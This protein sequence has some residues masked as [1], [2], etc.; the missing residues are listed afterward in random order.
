MG[1]LSEPVRTRDRVVDVV[2]IVTSAAAGFLVAAVWLEP[3]A[4][5][6]GWLR[7]TEFVLGALGCA[8][9]WWRRERPLAV[10]IVLVVLGAFLAT[11]SF[12]PLVALYTVALLRPLPAAL[13]LAAAST[14]SVAGQMLVRPDAPASA[15]LLIATQVA[16]TVAATAA[17]LVIR[18]RRQ[19][20]AS[21]RERAVAAEIE[22]RLRADQAQLEAR[23]E[24]AREM[25]D[26]LGHRLSLLSVQAGAL[27][28]NRATSADETAR[29]VE[30]IRHSSRK[31]LQDLREVIGVLRAPQGDI[32]L[33]GVAD[34]AALVADAERAGSPTTF[35]D[36]SGLTAGRQDAPAIVERTLYRFVQ[37]GLTNA[38][39]HAPGRA[40]T[41][42]VQGSPGA[43]VHAEIVNVLSSTPAPNEGAPPGSGLRGLEERAVLVGG[44][45]AHSVESSGTWRL[46]MRLPWP[47]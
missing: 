5:W 3:P 1:E 8:S 30:E 31:A 12:A 16:S 24:L 20:I 6:P 14:V 10:G 44:H 37:E 36:A 35:V 41:V 4:D 26:V 13:A 11:V 42:H 40:V 47:A 32:P 46:S 29:A 25:H 38:R 7:T 9:L 39:K 34:I 21:L 45:V 22:S 15:A 28:Y 19:L 23:E 43:Y 18:S 27:S 33:P 17:G 2:L